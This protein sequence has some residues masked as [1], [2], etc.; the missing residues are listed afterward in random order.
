MLNVILSICYKKN[1]QKA[2]TPSTYVPG[3]VLKRRVARG[4]PCC[5][6]VLLLLGGSR[7]FR[8]RHFCF[9]FTDGSLKRDCRSLLL[10][11]T[12]SRLALPVKR[13][14]DGSGNWAGSR[15]I[16]SDD[17]GAGSR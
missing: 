16:G 14:A 9:L 2:C 15:L 12:A 5:S 7:L 8:V 1:H 6:A 10:L 17:S 3:R 11:D 13:R 4:V